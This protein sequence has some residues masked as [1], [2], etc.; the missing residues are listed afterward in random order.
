MHTAHFTQGGCAAQARALDMGLS[1]P[2]FHDPGMSTKPGPVKAFP[3]VTCSFL[4][5]VEGPAVVSH[6]LLASRI[7]FLGNTFPHMLLR[8]NGNICQMVCVGRCGTLCVHVGS[9][10]REPVFVSSLAT[11]T[12]V[13]R[14]YLRGVERFR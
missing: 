11:I 1:L 12:S 10:E 9:A 7:F 4:L 2:F 6:C 8:V 3:E 13:K 5:R 14:S